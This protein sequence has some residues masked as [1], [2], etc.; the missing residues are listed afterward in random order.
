MARVEKYTGVSF[1][2]VMKTVSEQFI[3]ML[4]TEIFKQQKR[5]KG[6]ENNEETKTSTSKPS[7]V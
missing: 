4:M 7:K 5:K 6:E 1:K 3:P 2:E